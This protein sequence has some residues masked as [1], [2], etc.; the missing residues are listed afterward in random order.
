MTI[1]CSET[2]DG[3]GVSRESGEVVLT[4]SDHLPWEDEGEHFR[5]LEKKCS[6]YLDFVRSGQLFEVVPNAD[7]RAIRIDIVCKYQPSDLAL[8][9]LSAAR[10]QLKSFGIELSFGPLPEGY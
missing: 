8:E 5:L 2:V 1:E 7:N 9:F 10:L 4:I 6:G 3:V